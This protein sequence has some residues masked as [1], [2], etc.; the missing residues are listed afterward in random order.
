MGESLCG[1]SLRS[2]LTGAHCGIH[3]HFTPTSTWPIS[4]GNANLFQ[5]LQRFIASVSFKG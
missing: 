1:G 5:Q 2:H 3:Q 4:S